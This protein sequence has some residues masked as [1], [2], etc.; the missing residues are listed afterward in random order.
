LSLAIIYSSRVTGFLEPGSR[1]TDSFEEQIVSKDKY[2]SPF[3]LQIEAVVI[4]VRHVVF[5]TCAVLKVGEYHSDIPPVLA[6][7]YSVT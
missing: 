4:I 5:A 3:S 1:K 6:V 2:P 7:G